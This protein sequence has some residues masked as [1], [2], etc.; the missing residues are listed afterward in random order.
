MSRR[1]NRSQSRMVAVRLRRSTARD[2]RMVV[3]RQTG[4]GGFTLGELLIVLAIMSVVVAVALPRWTAS[5]QKYRVA[6][7]A[8]RI[9]ADIARTQSAA[10]STSA[11]K[12]ITFTV[13]SSQYSISGVTSLNGSSATNVVAL[14]HEPYRCSLV[15]VWGQTGTQTI[16]FDGHGIPD[17]GGTII[18]ALNGQQ[19]S[20]VVDA[21]TGTAVVP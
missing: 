6:N 20:I 18:V 10:Y 8:A 11:P 15:S 17:K 14:T 19:K 9:A 1:W 7:A 12:T 4:R 3:N 21:A 2:C 16:T 5:L 13:S